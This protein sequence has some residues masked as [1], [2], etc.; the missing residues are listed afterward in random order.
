MVF[1]T[2][3]RMPADHPS[4]S[5]Q[6]LRRR[7][8]RLAVLFLLFAAVGLG[9]GAWQLA[10]SQSTTRSQLRHTYDTRATIASGVIESLFNVAFQQA[11]ATYGKQFGAKVTPAAL[12]AYAKL[13]RAVYVAVTRADGSVVAASAGTPSGVVASLAPLALKSGIALGDITGSGHSQSLGLA[14]RFKGSDGPR[15]LISG[16][17]AALFVSFLSGS[18]SRLT[19]SKGDKA[20]VLDGNGAVLGAASHENPRHPEPPGKS[21]ISRVKTAPHGFYTQMG[22]RR[23]YASAAQPNSRWHVAV[24]VPRSTLYRS[25]SGSSRWLPWVILGILAFALASIALLVRRAI[26]AGAMVAE[27]NTQLEASQDRLRDRA[28]E[29]QASNA[30]LQRSNADLE[31]FAYV[32]SHD[33]SAPLRAVAGF[34]Q[35]LGM[36]YKGRLDGDADDFIGHMQDGVDR[37]QRIIDDLLAYSRVDRGGLQAERVDLDAIY[38]EVLR[39]LAPDIAERDAV[40]TKDPLGEAWGEAG[41]LSQV[42]QNLIANGLKFTAD[43]TRPEVHVSTARAGDRVRVSVRDNGIGID[44]EHAERI[45][46]MFQRLHNTEDYPGTGIGLAISQKI[47]DRHGGTIVIAPAPGGGTVFT[48]DLPARRPA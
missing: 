41:Q 21:L 40:V 33:L 43:G 6:R 22:T 18:L 42:L 31:Q 35:L 8:T 46:K 12:A 19:P 32:A 4:H 24:T 9:V 10:R 48:F 28:V 2:T 23:Y 30:E 45:F 39:G 14:I 36:R 38:D 1:S 5:A 7:G 20:Y 27:I 17:P 11:T 47:I 16:S 26:L 15:V 13:N 37:M 25:T 34:S 44:P 29:L 3:R